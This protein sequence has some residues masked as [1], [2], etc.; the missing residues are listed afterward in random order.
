L[1][2]QHWPIKRTLTVDQKCFQW[3]TVPIYFSKTNA[4][5]SEISTKIDVY[6]YRRPQRFDSCSAGVLCRGC[7]PVTC[8]TQPSIYLI[9]LGHPRIAGILYSSHNVDL[10]LFCC[11]CGRSSYFRRIWFLQ[12]CPVIERSLNKA[13]HCKC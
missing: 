10:V 2:H 8:N 6:S 3:Y 13:D 7:G 5:K 4:Q 11:R 1:K 9:H 12:L